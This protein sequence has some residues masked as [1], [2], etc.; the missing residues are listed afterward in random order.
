MG[1]PGLFRALTDAG[2]LT[3]S[4]GSKIWVKDQDMLLPILQAHLD[5]EVDFLGIDVPCVVHKSAEYV[6]GY[7]AY[8]E[9]EGVEQYTTLES[10]ARALARHVANQVVGYCE[11]YQP[12]LLFLAFDG[13]IPM[14]KMNE[15]RKRRYGRE[16]TFN[17]SF[18]NICLTSGSPMMVKLRQFLLIEIHLA[19]KRGLVKNF[20]LDHETNQ[21]EGEHK[22]INY[23]RDDQD[24][25]SVLISE[26]SDV[27]LIALTVK[28]NCIVKRAMDSYHIN[29][30]QFIR[31]L[32][33]LRIDV[34][35]FIIGASIVGNDF[36][37]RHDTCLVN[38]GKN[39]VLEAL[40]DILPGKESMLPIRPYTYH[41]LTEIFMRISQS[42]SKLFE[43]YR[44][45][46][47]PEDRV[48]YN[49][50]PL[51]EW[52]EFRTLW[53]H[54]ELYPTGGEEI[55][56][57]ENNEVKEAMCNSYVQSLLWTGL[58]YNN[59]P[60][61]RM[62]YYDFLKSPL[63]I[64]LPEF[65]ARCAVGVVEPDNVLHTDTNVYLPTIAHRAF[66]FPEEC[67]TDTAIGVYGGMDPQDAEV[68]RLLLNDIIQGLT[69]KSSTP[70]DVDIATVENMSIKYVDGV[71]K[72][73]TEMSHAR[74]G[75]KI[76]VSQVKVTDL[77]DMMGLEY[78]NQVM[79]L[80]Y[81]Q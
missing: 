76:V 16:C 71:K 8:A 70:I 20:I 48:M 42:E 53:Y 62:W 57:S 39:V 74:G 25:R 78:E 59:M 21:G 23:I 29:I 43:G 44:S 34:S 77:C 10:S 67:W 55:V 33:D 31:E 79:H 19:K 75:E 66:I 18:N 46:V 69:H 13:V 9:R 6:F 2:L 1:V 3:T 40:L 30:T 81:G 15:Q 24:C 49:T 26:D 27:V 38:E 58:Y 11:T 7:G 17:G 14:A 64:D 68:C 36:V 54:Y 73:V 41:L 63:W 60:C 12:D 35:N 47:L 65:C 4:N 22:M 50:S 52:P 80:I 28:G 51:N 61:S 72:Y 45:R 5:G 32:R 37:P 56:E